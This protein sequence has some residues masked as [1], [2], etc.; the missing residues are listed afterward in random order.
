MVNDPCRGGR[1][2]EGVQLFGISDVLMMQDCLSGVY[3]RAKLAGIENWLGLG[4]TVGVKMINL[5]CN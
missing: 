1:W 5:T 3:L 4:V 2:A